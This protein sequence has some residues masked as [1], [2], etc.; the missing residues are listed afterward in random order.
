MKVT[1]ELLDNFTSYQDIR[2]II[3]KNTK[4]LGLF[5]GGNY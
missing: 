1:N 2:V 5:N 3:I 4:N